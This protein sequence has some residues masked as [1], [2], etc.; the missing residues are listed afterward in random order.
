MAYTAGGAELREGPD[1]GVVR[2]CSC[3]ETRRCGRTVQEGTPAVARSEYTRLVA[4]SMAGYRYASFSNIFPS[5][6]R[7]PANEDWEGDTME[8]DGQAWM[9]N[10]RRKLWKSTCTRA[11]L[12]VSF[13]RLRTS[14]VRS[15]T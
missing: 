7:S 6:H 11:A 5:V 10:S 3:R 2:V 8:E 9:G 14:P 13:L 1:A 12:N 15:L 4:I